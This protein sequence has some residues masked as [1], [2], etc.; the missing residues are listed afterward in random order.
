MAGPADK[1]G[2]RAVHPQRGRRCFLSFSF[3]S[4]REKGRA[5]EGDRVEQTTPGRAIEYL[6]RRFEAKEGCIGE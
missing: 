3:L 6:R 2:E 5:I 1:S 4:S